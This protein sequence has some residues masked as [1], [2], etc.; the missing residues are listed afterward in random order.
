MK[1][2]ILGNQARAM[3]NFWPALFRHLLA[4]GHETLCLVPFPEDSLDRKAA[5]ELEAMGAQPRF[6]RLDRKGLNPLH[7]AATV[8]T[9]FSIFKKERPD[10]LFAST[11]KPVIWGLPAARLAGISNRYAMITG[12]G[13]AF[14]NDSLPKKALNLAVRGLYKVALS[15]AHGIFFQNMDDQDV[16]IRNHILSAKAP[17]TLFPQ[18]TGVD[19][20]RFNPV[21]LPQNGP[22]FLLVAR[23]LE[24]KGIR[25]FC[26]AAETLKTTYPD[27]QFHILGP[28]ENGAGSVPVDE[29]HS[30]MERDIVKYLGKTEDVRPF[31]ANASVMVLPSYREGLPCSLMEGMA[32]GRCAIA[33]DVPGCRDLVRPEANGLLVPVRNIPAL[34]NAMER[35]IKEPELISSL[36][37]NARNIIVENYDARNVA[38][39]IAAAMGA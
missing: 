15:G 30:Y 37:A 34:A 36:G 35:L 28:E 16:F 12:L 26:R 33:T 32:M 1:I 2:A 18:G 4:C 9:L 6:Y 8:K 24:A 27:A 19:I 39:N 23:L 13:F 5:Y 38:A 11:I 14:E 3:Y 25:E 20:E 29:L 17:V 7:D 31:I 21:P 10:I 22:V